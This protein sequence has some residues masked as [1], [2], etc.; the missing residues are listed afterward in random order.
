M[1]PKDFTDAVTD[2]LR[3][4]G[5]SFRPED[6]EAFAAVAWMQ[7]GRRP[8]PGF[9]AEQFLAAMARR[10]RKRLSRSR[11][12][13]WD[14]RARTAA[15]CAITAFWLTAALGWSFAHWPATTLAVT[16]AVS[17]LAAVSLSRVPM[18]SRILRWVLLVAMAT[19]LG[20][21]ALVVLLVTRCHL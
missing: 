20:V 4:R 7:K 18:D 13:L 3:R 19:V 17:I 11:W 14:K 10:G 12:R 6:V 9:C 21:A 1:T 16:A 15:V 8:D 2:K 5:A